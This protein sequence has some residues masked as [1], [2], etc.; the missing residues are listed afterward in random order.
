MNAVEAFTNLLNAGVPVA[1]IRRI[2]DRKVKKISR[3]W[4]AASV[5]IQ[6][7]GVEMHEALTQAQKN[8]GMKGV[9]K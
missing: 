8:L 3:K 2:I 1:D 9:G 6:M 7:G 5:K 4:P